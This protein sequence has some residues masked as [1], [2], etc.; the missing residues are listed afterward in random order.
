MCSPTVVWMP[1]YKE[2]SYWQ[3][4]QAYVHS[5]M[6]TMR[7]NCKKKVEEQGAGKNGWWSKSHNLYKQ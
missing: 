2:Q 4:S 5:H 3:Q 7:T 1:A 6:S